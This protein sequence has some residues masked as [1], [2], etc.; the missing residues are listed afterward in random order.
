MSKRKEEIVK[1]PIKHI[2]KSEGERPLEGV[3]VKETADYKLVKPGRV[4]F[5]QMV[6]FAP[7]K[8]FKDYIECYRAVDA[9]LKKKYGKT[10]CEM[11]CHE[12]ASFFTLGRHDMVCLWDAPDLETYQLMIAALASAACGYGTAETQTVVICA[13]HT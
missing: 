12:I 11:G 5:I 3:V 9:E 13:V 4:L 7:G 2:S 6:K 10:R 8:G 1:L